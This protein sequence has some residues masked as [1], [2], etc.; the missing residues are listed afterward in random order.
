MLDNEAQC[1][2]I[3]AEYAM[4]SLVVCGDGYMDIHEACED[5]NVDDGDG[6]SAAC[7]IEEG[8]SCDA[9]TLHQSTGNNISDCT[10]ASRARLPLSAKWPLSRRVPA[11]PPP[12]PTESLRLSFSA[13]LPAHCTRP[14]P[15]NPPCV[16]PC[17]PN[18]PPSRAGPAAPSFSQPSAP[19]K[20]FP[21]LLAFDGSFQPPP[22]STHLR[23][24]LPP[25]QTS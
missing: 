3:F 20:S 9:R 24:Q 23:T 7:L 15:P 6:C 14:L 19:S 8:W 10:E 16:L 5:G 11:I 13:P 2:G 4:P 25:R 17:P 21:A 18:A 12:P 22:S 1:P